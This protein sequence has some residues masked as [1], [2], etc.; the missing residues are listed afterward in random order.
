MFA[1]SHGKGDR[2][3][4]KK[5]FQYVA[6]I[7]RVEE[8]KERDAQEKKLSDIDSDVIMRQL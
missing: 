1:L 5:G 8:C 7:K 3:H 6:S 2:I 4:T